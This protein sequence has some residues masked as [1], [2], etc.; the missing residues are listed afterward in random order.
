MKKIFQIAVLLFVA[1]FSS[2]FVQAQSASAPTLTTK[3]TAEAAVQGIAAGVAGGSNSP[4]AA[5]LIGTS[6][7]AAAGGFN[8][9]TAIGATDK[10]QP[11]V[12]PVDAAIAHNKK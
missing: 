8:N 7:G 5:V 11:A 10:Q 6:A 4:A 12:Q 1:C 3:Q 9:K 2:N